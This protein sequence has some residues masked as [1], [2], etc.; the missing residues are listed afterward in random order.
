MSIGNCL[1]A[2]VGMIAS[3]AIAGVAVAECVNIKSGAIKTSDGRVI[4]PG[5]DEWGY[6]Y[7]AHS[8]N[9]GYCES[10]QNAAWCQPYADVDLLM[11]WDDAWL[12]NK[13]CDGDG[14]LDRHFGSPSYIGSDA[15]LTNHQSGKVEVNGKLRQWTYFIKIVAAP[16]D[17]VLDSGFWY[18]PGG[19]EIGPAIWGEFAIVQEILN[20]PS[21][22]AH[23]VLYKSP[24]GPGFGH[25]SKKKRR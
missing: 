21:A 6:N 1:A 7:Q 3:L 9:G 16:E 19:T 8:F 10:Y 11:K 23:G 18:T 2:T 20:D 14:L 24:V 22:G 13:D 17:A 25:I 15:W 4:K 5:F 12:S